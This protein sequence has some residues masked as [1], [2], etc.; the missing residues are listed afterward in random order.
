MSKSKQLL[1]KRKINKLAQ[2]TPDD[3]KTW[4]IM[5]ILQ[6]DKILDFALQRTTMAEQIDPNWVPD[7]LEEHFPV[8]HYDEL[9]KFY[10][11]NYQFSDS[12]LFDMVFN[13]LRLWNE[14]GRFS[15]LHKNRLDEITRACSKEVSLEKKSDSA[16]KKRHKVTPFNSIFTFL[17]KITEEVEIKVD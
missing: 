5:S 4:D 10:L 2:G 12:G 14:L 9:L 7:E 17:L 8:G 15:N 6:V 3:Q 13:T 11:T 1:K 16:F